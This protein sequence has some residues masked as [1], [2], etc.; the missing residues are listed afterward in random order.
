MGFCIAPSEIYNFLDSQ[1]LMFLYDDEDTYW[2]ALER[3]EL[4]SRQALL[5]L[6]A[7]TLKQAGE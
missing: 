4:R 2:D 6:K 3:R 5:E 1:E 7:E